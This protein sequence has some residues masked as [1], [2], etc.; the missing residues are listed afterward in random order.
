MDA[1]SQAINETISAMPLINYRLNESMKKHS[2]FKIGG[3]ARALF[4]PNNTEELRAIC[5]NFKRCDVAPLIIGNGTNLLFNDSPMNIVVIKTTLLDG[6]TLT[7]GRQITAQSGVALSK[8]AVFACDN[9]LTG[10]EFAH[11]IPGTLGGAI[12]MNAGAYDGEMKD[13]VRSTTVYS[14]NDSIIDIEGEQHDFSYRHSRFSYSN[15][16]VLSSTIVLDENDPAI[17]RKKMEEYSTRRRNS[18]PLDLPSAGSVFKRPEAGKGYAA[19]LIEQAQLKGF[20][21]GG[22]QVSTKHSGFIVNLGDAAFSDVIAVIDYVR[23]TVFRK[24]EVELEPEIK[25]IRG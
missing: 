19:Q 16:I 20:T 4:L 24:F 2:S 1:I 17:I 18:Q 15:E 10:L 13:C 21:K 23:E 8:L 5:S 14:H 3:N 6:I 12:T 22:A 9:N 11:G 25:I 7:D